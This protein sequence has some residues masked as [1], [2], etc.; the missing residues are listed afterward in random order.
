MCSV[1]ESS[2]RPTIAI[3]GGTGREGRGLARRW[4][5]ARLP[6]IIGSRD[7]ARAQSVARELADDLAGLG[8]LVLSGT[9]NLAAARGADFAVLAVPYAAQGELLV[10]VRPALAGKVLITPVVP[11]RPPR[12]TVVQLPPAGS[13][14]AE[15]QALLGEATAVVAAFHNVAAVKLGVLGT[16]AACDVLVCGDDE[17]AKD[18]VL[19]LVA[20]AGLVGYDAGPL[21]NAGVVEG[22]ASILLGINRRYG[23]RAA[24]LRISGMPRP[25]DRDA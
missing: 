13:A 15:A 20:V 14:A 5:A 10:S 23:A 3:L 2:T 11:L 25:P 9:D 12:I 18:Q 17:T 21:A 6:V 16:D 7:V 8:A 1:T 24:G 4:A 19:E 22:M